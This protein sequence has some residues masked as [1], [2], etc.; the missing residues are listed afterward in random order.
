MLHLRLVETA[1][2][3]D[4]FVGTNRCVETSQLGGETQPDEKDTQ[5]LEQDARDRE[6]RHKPNLAR[7]D[8]RDTQHENAGPKHQK[9]Q[10]ENKMPQQRAAL[11][12]LSTMV[13][14]F[15]VM[16]GVKTMG[17][18]GW[19]TDR[20]RRSA[21]LRRRA[22]KQVERLADVVELLVQAPAIV[23]RR[24]GPAAVAK[25]HLLERIVLNRHVRHRGMDGCRRGMW[26]MDIVDREV[27]RNVARGG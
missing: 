5:H 19:F 21:D 10:P 7:K 25:A 15:L 13:T 3:L 2:G 9:D 6:I 24:D 1:I 8:R 11:F 27:Q 4:G 18:F 12:F 23:S 26:A 14:V 20:C 17:S 16:H 22:G